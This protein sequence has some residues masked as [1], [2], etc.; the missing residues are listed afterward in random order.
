MKITIEKLTDISLLRKACES[1]MQAGKTSSVTLDS[2]YRCEHSPIRTQLFWITMDEL[3]TFVSVHCVRHKIGIEHYCRSNREDRREYI[4]GSSLTYK[5]YTAKLF[6]ELFTYK[7]GKL[8]WIDSRCRNKIKEGDEAGT[9]TSHGRWQ[10]NYEGKT[11]F[12]SIVVYM[13]R[14]GFR[15][16]VV[17]HIDR[18][19]LN[20][21]IENLRAATSAENSYNKKFS[22]KKGYKG[23]TEIKLKNGSTKWVAK[24]ETGGFAKTIGRYDSEHEAAIAYDRVALD[25]YGE[26]AALNFEDGEKIPN[27]NSPIMHSVLVNAESLINM[28]KKR[29]CHQAHPDTLRAMISIKDAVRTVDPDLVRYMVPQCVYRGGYCPEL[30][31]CGKYRVIRYDPELI[32]KRMMVE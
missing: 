27:R 15:P 17:D 28:A 10:I 23:V 9:L 20:D 6:N 16:P 8:Y 18:D 19:K 21:K 13:M 30:R 3:P 32:A 5:G 1:T 26:F 4:E 25:Y 24:I 11:L 22:K 14:F 7:D 31:P 12:R 2:M 29:L